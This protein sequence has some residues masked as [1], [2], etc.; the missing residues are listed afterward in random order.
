VKRILIVKMS[1]LG[2]ILHTL[3]ALADA[4]KALPDIRFDWV[5]E[6]AFSEIPLWHPLV[7]RVIPVAFRRWRRHPWAAIKSGEVRKFFDEIRSRSYDAIIDAQGLIKSAIV[8]GCAKGRRLGLDRA[9]ITETLAGLFYHQTFSVD[10]SRHALWRMR[11]IFSQALGYSLPQSLPDACLPKAA[12]LSESVPAGRN[13]IFLH[14]TTWPSKRWTEANWLA[15]AERL[16]VLKFKVRLPWC[17]TEEKR[18][19][20]QLAAQCRSIEVLPRMSLSD[21]ART[22]LQATG[23]V[24][25]DTGLAHLAAM[26]DVPTVI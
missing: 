5:V 24:A 22:L 23:V 13:I 15:L 18:M 11:N 21:I 6:E 3:P 26:L 19:A 7:D 8:T 4:G 2:D 10:P 14:G 12:W 20:E 17:N 16:N 9:S 1:S 25:I